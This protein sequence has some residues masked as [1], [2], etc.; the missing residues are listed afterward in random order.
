MVSTACFFAVFQRVGLVIAEVHA[1]DQFP[2]DDKI[3]ALCHDLGLQGLAGASCG[4]IF[5]GRLLAYS[6]IPARS[7]SRPFF[8]PLFPGQT[9]PFG[10]AHRAQQ[11]A[12]GGKALIQLVL[13]QRVAVFINGFAAHGGSGIVEGVAVLFG[14]LIQ[15]PEGLFYDLRAGAIAPDDSNIFFHEV[16][17]L[18][19]KRP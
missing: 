14:H 18:C 9:L 4:Q 6:P 3:N 17:L 8:R 2:H 11:H 16:L 10:A 13:G 7:R 5:A 19:S 15:H 12:V 1:A